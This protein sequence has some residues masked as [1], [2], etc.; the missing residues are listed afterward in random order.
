MEKR[1][2]EEVKTNAQPQLKA[3]AD[4]HPGSATKQTQ[5]ADKALSLPSSTHPRGSPL[6]A[7]V[8][9]QQSV[10]VVTVGPRPDRPGAV[11]WSH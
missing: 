8:R 7:L 2:E 6:R 4:S 1:W 11:P 10:L 3:A 9:A 5:D